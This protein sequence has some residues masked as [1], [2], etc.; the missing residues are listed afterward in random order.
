MQGASR[1]SL[2]Q[3]S[4]FVERELAGAGGSGGSD[5]DAE[6]PDAAAVG[7]ELFGVVA[8]IDGQVGLRR[9]LSD[10]SFEPDRKAGLVEAVLGSHVGATTL[11][12]L[13]ELVRARWSRMR[14]LPD[15]VETLAVLAVLIGADRAGESDD[16]EDEL[17][18]FG[19]IVE[20][21]PQLRDALRSQAL[22]DANKISLVS[23]LLEGKV[24]DSTLRLVTQV[25]TRPRGRSPED[26]LAEYAE[27]A[28]HRRARLVA[29]VTTA[30]V[31]SDDERERLRSALAGL[32]GH[33]V[34]LEI[35][36][37]ASLVGGVVVQVGDE[38]LDGSVAGRLAEARRRLE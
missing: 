8:V 23:A 1:A 36:I 37:D 5:T 4:A 20:A 7:D 11:A 25:A 27:V 9:A 28:A 3:A 32:Y 18:R 29:R 15:A 31:L 21:R 26:A 13:G 17:F 6:L 35:E 38:V 24:T 34:H 16:V 2:K 19:R 10:P 14:D 33:D 22:P 30:I 12:I